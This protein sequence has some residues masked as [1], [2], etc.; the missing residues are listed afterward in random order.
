VIRC[1][2]SANEVWVAR[3]TLSYSSGVVVR[4]VPAVAPPKKETK[5]END[6]ANGSCSS[7]SNQTS[8]AAAA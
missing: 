6:R 3:T 2:F 8:I 7:T 1:D 4:L 5:E